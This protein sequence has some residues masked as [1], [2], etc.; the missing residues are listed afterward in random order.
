VTG[1]G[2]GPSTV[3]K[4]TRL[5]GARA[6]LLADPGDVAAVG[7]AD[8]DDNPSQFSREYRRY[9]IVNRGTRRYAVHI[10]DASTAPTSPKGRV[11]LLVNWRNRGRFV[12]QILYHGKP[13]GPRRSITVY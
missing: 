12:Y 13:A 6:R 9:A 1:A 10:W 3:Q 11:V 8:G 7:F 4:R 2:A 5:H